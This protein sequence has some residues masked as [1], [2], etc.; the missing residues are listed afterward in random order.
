MFLNVVNIRMDVKV[1]EQ[2]NIT[3]YITKIFYKRSQSLAKLYKINGL[4]Y[5]INPLILKKKNLNTKEC[6]TLY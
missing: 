2:Q 6:N 1:K 5:L 4:G 3:I